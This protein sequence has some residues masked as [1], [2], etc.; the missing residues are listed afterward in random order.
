MKHVLLSF[1]VVFSAILGIASTSQSQTS[2]DE[3]RILSLLRGSW[4]YPT[5]EEVHTLTFLSDTKLEL[6]R[7]PQ[8]YSLQRNNFVI[9]GEGETEFYAFE[10]QGNRLLVTYP[11]GMQ[12]KFIRKEF[13]KNEKL[14]VG[15]FYP[16][17]DTSWFAS[18]L[19]FYDDMKFTLTEPTGNSASKFSKR[20]GL[21]RQENN[22]IILAFDD[23]KFEQALVRFHSS[24]G[25]V[26]GIL[27]GGK[28]FDRELPSTQEPLVDTIILVDDYPPPPPPRPNPRPPCLTC[29]PP[30]CPD[31]LPIAVPVYYPVNPSPP[32]ENKIRDFGTQRVAS[33]NSDPPTGHREQ[34]TSRRGKP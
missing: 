9:S 27:F 6:D 12:A 15:A 14:L 1:T 3:H 4:E 20:S 10:I 32:V 8:S 5:Y 18:C 30:P 16:S 13:G 17:D 22:A 21:F 25:L 26:D 31:P 23:N 33:S 19:Q 34:P 24:D 7:I 28:L 2:F 29:A 11:D